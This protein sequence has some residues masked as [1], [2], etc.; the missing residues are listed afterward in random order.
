ME[1]DTV[2]KIKE[3]DKNNQN[4]DSSKSPYNLLILS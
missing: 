3:N 4:E 2:L 1:I